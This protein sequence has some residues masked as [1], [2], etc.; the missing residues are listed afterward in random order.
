M[1]DPRT[2]VRLTEIALENFRG[3]RLRSAFALDAQVVLFVGPNGTGKTSVFDAFVWLLLGDIPRL[4][5]H[6]LRR[7]D[8][9]IVNSY[10][11]EAPAI[12]SLRFEAAGRPYVATRTGNRSKSSLTVRSANSEVEG[13]SLQTLVGS[14]QLP[15]DELLRTSGLLQQDDLRSLL[16]DRPADRYRL[17]VRLLG[18]DVLQR[19]EA[20]SRSWHQ[21]TKSSATDAARAAEAERVRLVDLVSR[22]ET[23]QAVVNQ[24]AAPVDL[25]ELRSALAAAEGVVEFSPESSKDPAQV[26]SDSNALVSEI[27][28]V[29]AIVDEQS[30]E[31]PPS[32][33]QVALDD[34]ESRVTESLVALSELAGQTQ[35]AGAA[36]SALE[37]SHGQLGSLAQIAIPLLEASPTSADGLHACP[38]CTTLVDEGSV[39]AG[40]SERASG[41][42]EL[43]AAIKD[44]ES[45][46]TR[47]KKAEESVRLLQSRLAEAKRLSR[48]SSERERS[49]RSLLS[50]IRSFSSLEAVSLPRVKS[51]LDSPLELGGTDSSESLRMVLPEIDVARSHLSSISVVAGQVS[52]RI[53][54]SLSLSTQSSE[55]PRLLAAIE[56]GRA[57]LAEKVLLAEGRQASESDASELARQTTIAVQNIV[58]ERFSAVEPLLNDIYG[59]LDPHPTFKKLGFTIEP[60]WAKGTATAT[61]FDEATSV[62]ANP[63][64]IFSAA[65]TNIVVLSAFLAL[66]WA[67]PSGS[68]PFVLMDDPLQSLDDVNVL[69]FADLLRQIRSRKQ[70][71]LSTHEERFARLI[72][73]KLTTGGDPASISIHRFRGWDRNGPVREATE[74]SGGQ[75]ADARPA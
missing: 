2:S 46:R 27:D 50:R 54:A 7:T 72:E 15:V 60:Y 66:G 10:D 53:Q 68:L 48:E 23:S 74:V 58:A 69:G 8:D 25:A 3:V 17:L 70:I 39:A 37:H 19:F 59:R 73:R 56:S 4:A 42:I 31:R 62:S 64:L 47:Q 28:S 63:M 20:K 67:A 36:L 49:N 30:T 29:L 38:V 44:L 24:R 18:L 16:R 26:A 14:S 61:V 21:T 5:P 9:Y 33:D 1:V 6:A 40:L 34:L 52:R 35:A 11:P 71:V 45:A 41:S 12:V 75:S 22:L 65:Q 57:S 51:L 13:A 43:S 55:V 32:V